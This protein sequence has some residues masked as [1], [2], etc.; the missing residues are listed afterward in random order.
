MMITMAET[1]TVPA[2]VVGRD[3]SVRRAWEGESPLFFLSDVSDMLGHSNP[4]EMRKLV[5]PD[6]LRLAEV[7]DSMGRKQQGW[8]VTEGGLYTVLLRSDKPQAKRFRKWVTGEVLPALRRFGCYPPPAEAGDHILAEIHTIQH[9]LTVAAETRRAQLMLE[10]RQAQLERA[11]DRVET[12]AVA[13]R[14]RADSNYGMFSILGYL[15]LLRKDAPLA[16]A[17]KL[18][19]RASALC[20]AEGIEVPKVRDPRFGE[21]GVYPQHVLEQLLGPLPSN[22]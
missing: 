14:D 17:A 18:G 4:S 20:R 16:E 1:L 21:V 3:H 5:D 6:D 11:I 12:I 19:R 10:H 7:I 22:N 13:A 15:R 2:S 9:A 8:F